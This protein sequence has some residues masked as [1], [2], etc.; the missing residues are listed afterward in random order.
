M[1]ANRR[2]V[3]NF[4]VCMYVCVSSIEKK[5]QITVLITDADK[6]NA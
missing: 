1:L 4:G 6:T 5:K 3:I 2:F